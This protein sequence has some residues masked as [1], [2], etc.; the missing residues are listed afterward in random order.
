MRKE[1]DL[2]PRYYDKNSNPISPTHKI[3]FEESN[4]LQAIEKFRK[5]LEKGE[6]GWVV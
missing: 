1:M 4:M 5:G 3:E 6:P 2:R